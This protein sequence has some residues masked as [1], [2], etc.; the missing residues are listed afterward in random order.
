MDAD[1]SARKITEDPEIQSKLVELFGEGILLRDGSLSRK[2]LAKIVFSEPKKGALLNGLIHPL[3]QLEFKKSCT[4]LEAGDILVY[5]IPLLF[6][7][8]HSEELDLR[9]VTDAPQTLRYERARKRNNWS[10]EEFLLR[11]QSQFSAEKKK[12]LADLVLINEYSMEELK[13]AGGRIYRAVQ[14]ARELPQASKPN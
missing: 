5:D 13:E 8:G 14:E 3:V 4:A 10:K 9:I 2:E 7:A 11:E 1:E 12:Q 6:E